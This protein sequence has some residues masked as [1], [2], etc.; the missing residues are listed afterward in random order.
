MS[1]KTVNAS[2]YT[3]EEWDNSLRTTFVLPG[4]PFDDPL[5]RETLGNLSVFAYR[6]SEHHYF[7][8]TEPAK[9][10]NLPEE[11]F[12]TGENMFQLTEPRKFW[13]FQLEM[14]RTP[15]GLV[16][17]SIPDLPELR[18]QRK[19]RMDLYG[20]HVLWHRFN[21]VAFLREINPLVAKQ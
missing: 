20:D 10:G 18:M 4:D 11:F 13:R 21:E 17:A 2:F 19:K 5:A 14:R 6:D 3:T 1:R 15:N 7:L 8:F 16:P 12:T 9:H